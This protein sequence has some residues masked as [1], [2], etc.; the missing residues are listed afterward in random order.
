MIKIQIDNMVVEELLKEAIEEKINEHSNELLFWDSNELK[1][2]TC[3]SWNSIQDNFF[4]DPNFPKAKVG[5]KWYYPAK[6][7]EEFLLKWL[8][9]KNTLG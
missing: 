9:E 2:R 5:G 3:M 7:T 8:K 6:E 1:R 4:H